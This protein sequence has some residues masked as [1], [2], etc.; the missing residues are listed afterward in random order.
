[1]PDRD[2]TPTE[3]LILD[4]LAARYRCGEKAWTFP[5]ML[6]PALLRLEA[7][8]LIHVFGS[9]APK[10]VRARLTEQGLAEAL[11]LSYTP[12]LPTLAQAVAML[13]HKNADIIAWLRERGLGIGAGAGA[14]ILAVRAELS[15]LAG[16]PDA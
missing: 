13:P 8:G 12:P 14:V 6:N 9:P 4:V 10:A 5:T 7:A 1:M 2:H 15:K 3:H 11:D 16:E